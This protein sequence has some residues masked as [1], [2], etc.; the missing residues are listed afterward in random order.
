M[1]VPALS[2]GSALVFEPGRLHPP[3]ESNRRMTASK[4]RVIGEESHVRGSRNFLKVFVFLP[5]D[6]DSSQ[7]SA[8]AWW[9]PPAYSL[10]LAVV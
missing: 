5:L 7:L 4:C 10:D 8:Y 1:I 6:N 2:T 3:S 9:D